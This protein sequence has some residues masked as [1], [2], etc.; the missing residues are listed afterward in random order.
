[1]IR[2]SAITTQKMLKK[3][4]RIIKRLGNAQALSA[5][6]KSPIG[7]FCTLQNATFFAK[8][9]FAKNRANSSKKPDLSGFFDGYLS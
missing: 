6:Q 9:H 5:C 2:L 4:Y 8:L 7:L 3:R 1:M